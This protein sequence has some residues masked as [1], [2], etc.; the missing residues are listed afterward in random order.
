MEMVMGCLLFEFVRL[1]VSQQSVVAVRRLG[2]FSLLTQ[3][4]KFETLN[5]PA[6]ERHDFIL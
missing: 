6:I 2:K 4:D 5:L 3:F 1:F